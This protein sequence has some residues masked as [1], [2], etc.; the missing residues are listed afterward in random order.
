MQNYLINKNLLTAYKKR[1]SLH[2][3]VMLSVC[4][5][6]KLWAQDSLRTA[7]FEADSVYIAETESPKSYQKVLHA[8]PLF[9]DLLRD[10]GLAREKK[11]GM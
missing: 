6:S 3:L 1:A 7:R 5:V 2:T 4:C 8:E 10:L 9:T 11:S